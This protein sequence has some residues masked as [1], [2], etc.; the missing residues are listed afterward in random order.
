MEFNI[1][2]HVKRNYSSR[3]DSKDRLGNQNFMNSNYQLS[4]YYKITTF[5]LN[6]DKTNNYLF[7]FYVNSY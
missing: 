3:I 6:H 1:I 4:M 5:L 2:W 7:H